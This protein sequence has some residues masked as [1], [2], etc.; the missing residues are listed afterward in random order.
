MQPPQIFIL[1]LDGT[2]SDPASGI[3]QCLNYSLSSFG[4]PKHSMS[5]ISPY[6]GPPLDYSFR[7]ITGETSEERIAEMVAKYRERYGRVGYAENM[8]YPGIPGAILALSDK[9]VLLGVCTSKRADFAEK[10]LEMFALRQ[11]ISFVSGGDVGV[12]KE[13]QLRE[14]LEDGTIDKSAVMIGDRAIDILAARANG[15]ASVGVL[16]GYGSKSELQDAG[17]GKIIERPDQLP[18]LV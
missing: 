4:Y 16:W 14:L 6:I 13:N 9:G 12:K 17:P 18:D 3:C 15:L 11:Y 1:D 8:L 10:I 7:Q 5:D 2:I